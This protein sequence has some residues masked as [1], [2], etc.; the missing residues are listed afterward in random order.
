[1]DRSHSFWL[2][3]NLRLILAG[4]LANAVAGLIYVWSLFILPLETTL[5]LDRSD[6]GAISS[7][8]L[9]CY[10]FG[11]WV[12][13]RVSA[14]L[15]LRG[16]AGLAFALIVG[17]HLS[18]GLMPSGGM[19]AAGYGVAFGTGAGLGY[20]LALTLA[21]RLPDGLRARAI[22]MVLA[23]FAL[24][25]IV[26]PLV[27]GNWIAA[28]NPALAFIG[29]GLAA[30]LP[31]LACL[32]ILPRGTEVAEQ[33]HVQGA[34]APDLPFA[35]MSGIF[36]CLCFV[37]LVVV[38]QAVAMA[39]AGGLAA[40]SRVATAMTTGYLIGSLFGAPL[41][42][43]LHERLMLALLA[44]V[45][46][47][48]TAAIAGGTDMLFLAGAA[49]VG[50]SFGGSGSVLPVLVGRR[51]GAG[52]ISVVYGRMILAYGLAGLIA[53]GLAGALYAAQGSYGPTLALSLGLAG[54]SF[55][56]AAFL[57]FRPVTGS[58]TK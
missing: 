11:I 35:V 4:L 18:F 10:T 54:L 41:A 38:S 49:L 47:L 17:G 6:L 19:L 39:A 15:G 46:A 27:L 16:T 34:V 24:S 45:C 31:G 25:G 56:A 2:G 48:G 36:F 23:A 51:Y 20:G 53:P 26:L 40:P 44:A 33:A 58:P 8:S 3:E 30:V 12:L 37:G 13:P 22:G 5:G 57:P 32:L 1:M 42:D 43:T 50:L 52:Q 21:A 29:I 28:A 7:V 9:V 55:G 14:R